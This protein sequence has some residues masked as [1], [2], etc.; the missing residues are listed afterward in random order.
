MII[1]LVLQIKI[2]AIPTRREIRAVEFGLASSIIAR[3]ALAI[4]PSAREVDGCV[5]AVAPF[6]SAAVAACCGEAGRGED[7]DEGGELHGG[8]GF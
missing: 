7:S 8:D 5:S 4:A 6:L 2:N 1:P 3:A